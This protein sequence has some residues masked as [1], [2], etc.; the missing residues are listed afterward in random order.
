MLQKK[1]QRVR[2]GYLF[3][4]GA[5][6]IIGVLQGTKNNLLL[7]DN[8]TDHD[9]KLAFIKSITMFIILAI[10]S[11]LLARWYYKLKDKKPD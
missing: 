3:A 7:K 1:R 11:I 10:P 8:P 6:L 2:K 5:S 9:L 4:V